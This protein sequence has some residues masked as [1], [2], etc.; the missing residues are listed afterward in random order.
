M[1][2]AKECRP[3]LILAGASAYPRTL[4]F[5]KFREIADAVG[6]R[7]MVDMAHIAGLVAAGVHPSP[8]PYADVVTTTTH[9][10]LRGPRGGM[11][12]CNDDDLYKKINSAVFPGT[13]GG[14]LEHII[15]AK[16]VCLGEALKPGLWAAGGRQRRGSGGKADRAGLPAGLRRHGQ[17][18]DSGGHPALWPHRQGV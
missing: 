13:Q 2:I 7:L 8:I 18:S 9:K 16:A 5:A 1:A 12:L 10:T 15:A 14:P 3:K 6:A 11:I 4:D 17:P